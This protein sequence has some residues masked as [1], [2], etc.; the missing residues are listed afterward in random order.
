M[1]IVIGNDSLKTFIMKVQITTPCSEDWN[2]MKI[3]LISRH[4]EKCEK[5]V[6]DF[7]KM[8]RSEIIVYLLEHPNENVCGRMNREQFDFH[9]EDIPVLIDVLRKKGGNVSFL[10]MALVC[11]SLVSCKEEV[12]GEMKVKE[13]VKKEIVNVSTKGEISIQDSVKTGAN[14]VPP[15]V[16][17]IEGGS[18]I[19]EPYPIYLG[20]PI[21]EPPVYSGGI[22]IVDPYIE[23]TLERIEQFAEKMPEY[24]GGMNELYK[25][26]QSNLRYPEFEKE[27]G[28]QGTVY[29]QFVVTKEGIVKSPK[30]LKTV[31][32]SYN[33]DKEVLR[34][35]RMMPKWI[36]G[37]NG[38]KK[39]SVY[40]TMPFKFRLD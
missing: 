24:P 21:I 9:H 17:P 4:C 36:P 25:F 30:I 35:V 7:T 6:M 39:V 32:G 20:K 10:I 3:G 22:S 11:L 28:I 13:P 5:S 34:I 38:G 27:N 40:F 18:P 26:V 23:D 15:P 12:M 37:E 1:V 2:K 8:D 14:T 16:K 19:P 33:F 29:V 31:S